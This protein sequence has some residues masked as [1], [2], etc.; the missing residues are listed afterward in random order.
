MVAVW[1]QAMNEYKSRE[2]VLIDLNSIIL[3]RECVVH[4]VSKT[5]G[6]GPARYMNWSGSHPKPVPTNSREG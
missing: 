6:T 2:D 1:V 3:L 4:R 5:G